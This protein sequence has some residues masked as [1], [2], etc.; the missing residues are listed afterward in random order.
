[1]AQFIQHARF[2][3]RRSRPD[4]IQPALHLHRS[5]KTLSQLFNSASRNKQRWLAG[6]SREWCV[7]AQ[8]RHVNRAIEITDDIFVR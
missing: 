1:M 8:R 4:E 7:L 2:A 6:S 3:K 5:L